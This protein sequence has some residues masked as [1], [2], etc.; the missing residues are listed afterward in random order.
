LKLYTLGA[1]G[2]VLLMFICVLFG[3][4]Q[5]NSGIH[6]MK[7]YEDEGFQSAVAIN[8]ENG[9]LEASVLGE[10]ITSHDLDEKKQQ[11]EE[12]KAFNLLSSIGKGVADTI[13]SVAEKG[14]NLVGDIMEEKEK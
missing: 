3:M 5:A 9:N 12:M 10:N 8:K 6:K 11:L 2:I 7:G 14:V 4:Q 13:S 1:V